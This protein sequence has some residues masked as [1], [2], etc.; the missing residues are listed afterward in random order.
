MKQAKRPGHFRIGS[1]KTRE[2]ERKVGKCANS[3]TT[4]MTTGDEAGSRAQLLRKR[5]KDVLMVM[6]MAKST[7]ALINEG[8]FCAAGIFSPAL[9]G[10]R[11]VTE[12]PRSF[13]TS[14]PVFRPLPPA[15]HCFPLIRNR[16]S[17]SPL[18]VVPCNSG[19]RVNGFNSF[20]LGSCKSS[21]GRVGFH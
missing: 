12:P 14:I 5:G 13:A 18:P 11:R 1:E 21:A 19:D 15:S 10:F 6:K 20:L 16:C 9:L 3:R 8:S 7:P 2:R 4:T 17:P